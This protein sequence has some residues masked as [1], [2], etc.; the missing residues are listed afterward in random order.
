MGSG[1]GGGLTTL[2]CESEFDLRN[3]EKWPLLI[4][5]CCTTTTKIGEYVVQELMK[6][7]PGMTVDIAVNIMQGA[8]CNGTA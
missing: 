7:V 6:V 3:Q 4:E 1:K 2:G 8:H 5:S